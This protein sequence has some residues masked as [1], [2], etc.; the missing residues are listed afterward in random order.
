MPDE[1]VYGVIG[2]VFSFLTGAAST[3]GFKGLA[4]KFIRRDLLKFSSE[5]IDPEAMCFEF[6]RLDNEA[7]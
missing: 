1:G 6:K 7:R 2:Q 5:K 4:Q 3:S